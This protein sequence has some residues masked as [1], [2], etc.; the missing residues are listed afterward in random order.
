[1]SYKYAVINNK[2][3][4]YWPMVFDTPSNS[5]KNYVDQTNPAIPALGSTEVIT[6]IAPLISRH[7]GDNDFHACR[8]F[9]GTDI[10]INNIYNVFSKGYEHK[11]FSA[12]MWILFE[13]SIASKNSILKLSDANYTA[14]ELYTIEDN[15]YFE[16]NGTISHTIKKQIRNV[17]SKMHLYFSYYDGVVTL[18]INGISEE[19][20]E[21]SKTFQF[22]NLLNSKFHVGPSASNTSFVLSDIAFYDRLLSVQEIRSHMFWATRDS[23]PMVTT[24]QGST[25]SF[26]IKDLPTMIAYRKDFNNLESFSEGTFNNLSYQQGGLTVNTGAASSGYWTYNFT[27]ASYD[28]T[29]ALSISWDTGS[30][31]S[32]S[33]ASNSIQ[34]SISFNQGIT[35]Y[36][37]ENNKVIDQY[38]SQV[39]DL[40]SATAFIKVEIFDSGK[41]NI[42]PARLDNLSIKLYKSLIIDSES[43]GFEIAPYS[44]TYSLGKD[45]YSF[46]ARSKNFGIHFKPYSDAFPGS[47][48]ISSTSSQPYEAL[49][50][51]F[52]YNGG[53]GALMDNQ[54]IAGADLYVDNATS[55]LKWNISS[56]DKI[57]INGIEQVT[58]GYP[59]IE[60]EPYHIFIVYGALKT[61]PV[62]LNKDFSGSV[63]ESD[64]I[65]GYISLYPTQL[66]SVEVENRYISFLT[67]NS[68]TL[69]DTNNAFGS[70]IEYSGTA[71][72][73]NSGFTIMA[74]EHVY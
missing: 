46:I 63:Q 17:F 8:I 14:F 60:G 73:I 72:S 45:D 27:P 62:Y 9:P 36:P 38:V 47:A 30:L 56:V 53:G 10:T 37:V 41:N 19:S 39:S 52:K 65:F 29:K 70:L 40:S 35:F 61:T 15:L 42:Y 31:E 2:P 51:W 50:F 21:V 20:F 49:E 18:Y 64:C 67:I 68:A 12:E 43:G 26:D 71:S 25:Y 1:M 48:I 23:D 58:S 74:Y 34:V 6:D 32:L 4:G 28:D 24:A 22:H 59:I 69:N 55:E 7:V 54:D 33:S 11:N 16:I 13:E 3:V 66:S 44:N 5:F 57:Y